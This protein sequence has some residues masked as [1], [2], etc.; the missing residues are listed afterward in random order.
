MSGPIQVAT[1]GEGFQFSPF[2]MLPIGVSVAPTEEYS[3]AAVPRA[4]HAQPALVP[5]ILAD[6]SF[7]RDARGVLPAEAKPLVE[8]RGNIAS[9]PGAVIKAARDRVKAIRVELKRHAALQRELAELER[10][11]KA[12]KQKPEPKVRALRAG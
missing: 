2:G 1:A 6:G 5:A 12:A 3:G 4:A 9:T 10:L 8:L 7:A 11:L